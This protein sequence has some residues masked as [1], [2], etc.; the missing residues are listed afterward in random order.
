MKKLIGNVFKSIQRCWERNGYCIN[1]DKLEILD[2]VLLRSVIP[3][4]EVIVSYWFSNFEIREI[5]KIHCQLSLLFLP[6]IYQFKKYFCQSALLFLTFAQF[7]D[8]RIKYLLEYIPTYE[9][10]PGQYLWNFI[11]VTFSPS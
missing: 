3:T 1:V 2:P 9:G 4:T 8:Y 11:S 7:N 6:D 10:K 5:Q